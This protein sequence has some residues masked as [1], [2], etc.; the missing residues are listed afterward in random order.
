MIWA[1][2]IIG[3]AVGLGV[4]VVAAE[5]VPRRPRLSSALEQLRAEDVEVSNQSFRD[6]LGRAVQTGPFQWLKA[7][8]KDL[9]LVEVTPLQHATRQGI[10]GLF[11]LVA[12]PLLSLVVVFAG[13][14]P[15]V[16]VLYSLPL[17]ALL[18]LVLMWA[19]NLAVASQAKEK[20]QD[21]SRAVA[22]FIELVAVDRKSGSSAAVA[23][24]RSAHVADSWVFRRLQQSLQLAEFRGTQPWEAFK[25]LAAEIDVKEL[26]EL[27]DYMSLAG[28]EGVSVYEALRARGAGLR[29]EL[30]TQMRTEANAKTEKITIPAAVL[31]ML[32]LAFIA[33]PPIIRLLGT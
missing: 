24:Y 23:L 26:A 29:V 32:L 6:K 4:I 18:G 33:V 31:G 8:P 11:G 3:A 7:D 2:L 21:F 9:S 28:T 16:L 12:V 14:Y 20:R 15:A 27:A 22:A 1:A 5:F 10:A 17:A 19:A 25:Q 13:S 30:L